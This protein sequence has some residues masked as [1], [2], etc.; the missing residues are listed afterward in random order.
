MS[1]RI[2]AV[3]LAYGFGLLPILL[4]SGLTR[5]AQAAGPWYVAPGGSDAADCLSPATAC[6]TINA[7]IGKAS[8]G[9]TVYVAT[10]TY[11]A[12]SGREVVLINKSLTLS[13]G[14]DA[15]FAAQTGMAT[16][17]GEQVRRGITLESNPTVVI[18]RFTLQNG[19]GVIGGA[20][21]SD[22]Y[23]G[24]IYMPGGALTVTDSIIR[25]NV[26]HTLTF[27]AGGGLYVG[28]GSVVLAGTRI[29]ANI[30]SKGGG[31]YIVTGTVRL[32]RS[33][34]S[35]NLSGGI[36]LAGGTLLINHSALDGNRGYTGGGLYV[37][38]GSATLNNS[39]VSGN[40][41]SGGGG[42]Y[43][44]RDDPTGS[45]SVTLNSSTIAGN[46]AQQGG[47]I[48]FNVYGD[49]Q[50]QNTILADNI[51]AYGPNCL[52]GDHI[53]SL[54][55]NL[56]G[57]TADCSLT[58][59][60]GDLSGVSPN[61]GPQIAWPG[62]RPLS[63]G[64]PAI[65]AGPAGGCQGSEG[66]LLTDQ[67]QAPRVGVCDIGAYEFT[68]PGA[69]A[70]LLAAGGSGQLAPPLVSFSGVLQ[71]VVVDNLGTPVSNTLVTFAAPQAGASANFLDT[72]NPTMTVA[73][74]LG[75]QAASGVLSA[76]AIQ[77]SY[78]VTATASGVLTPLTF[79]LTNAGWYVSPAGDDAKDCLSPANACATINGALNKPTFLDGGT[80]LVATGIYTNS[81]DSAVV[82]ISHQAVL[83]GG[84]T[85]DFSSQ[86]GWSTIDGEGLRRG[87]W[88]A[89]NGR[90]T[91]DRFV[92]QNGS[93]P[94]L[95]FFGGGGIYADLG[96]AG[97]LGIKNSQII[98]NT[99]A[100][101]GGGI[102]QTGVLTLS[103]STVSNNISGQFG[104]GIVH[105]S[106]ATV[107]SSTISGNRSGTH[108]GGLANLGNFVQINNSTI[109]GNEA[110]GAGGGLY[111]TGPT[112]LN[113]V[114]VSDNTAATSGGGVQQANFSRVLLRN[115]L[116]A[117]NASA[118]GPDCSGDLTSAGYNLV[119]TTSQCAWVLATGDLLN[120]NAGLVPLLGSPG[121]HA[122]LPTS[123][124]IDAGN[125]GGCVG[126]L[127]PLLTDQRGQARVGVC[128]IGAFEYT[129]PGP[130]AQI[131]VISGSQQRAKPLAAYAQSLQARVLDSAGSPL[132]GT[133]V[134]FA[135]PAAGQSVVFAGGSYSHTALTDATGLATTG[136]FTAN[137]QLGSLAVTASVSGVITPGIYSLANVAWYV[138][139]AGSDSHDCASPAASCATINRALGQAVAGDTIYVATG[140]YTAP[141]GPD[142]VWITRTISLLGGWDAAFA[143]QTGRST[144]NGGGV[145]TG[146]TIDDGRGTNSPLVA[147][148]D[149]F[150][151]TNTF[152]N[153]IYGV[154]TLYLSRSLVRN[155]TGTGLT[156][157]RGT[158]GID[159]TSVTHHNIE[160][161]LADGTTLTL[162]NSTVSHNLSYGL[163]VSAAGRAYLYNAT[164]ANNGTL[165]VFTELNSQVWLRN[166]LVG[167][168]A[169]SG[170]VNS[171]GYNLV[172]NALGCS[173][174]ASVGDQ[175]NLAAGLWPELEAPAE[176]VPLLLGSR[177]INAGSPGGCLDAAGQ[178]LLADQR[179]VAR[180]GPCDV[181]AYEFD[182]TQT[183]L[184]FVLLP[185]V[186]GPCGRGL[187][188]E[189][190]LNGAPVSGVALELRF[191]NGS[192]WSTA[193]ATTTDST[194]HYDFA[195]MA[196]LLPGQRYYVRY[197]NQANT[198]G[199]L[200][201]WQ[202]RV[203]TSYTAGTTLD[204]GSFDIGDVVLTAPGE[205]ALVALPQTFTWTRRPATPTDSYEF[206]IYD[207][208]DSDPYG[209]TPLLGYV[210][211]VTVT[212][213]PDGFEPGVSYV[214]EVWIY[215]P[216]G[217]VGISRESRPVSF[218]NVAAASGAAAGLDGGLT[219]GHRQI[220]PADPV[221]P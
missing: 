189:V 135:A 96:L 155:S 181:G 146:I 84:W 200:Y 80:V 72:G 55:H 60:A 215:S 115:S 28:A 184:S 158:V 214:W 50:L 22:R 127:G 59:A 123:P 216:D 179:G 112:T 89:S 204:L 110:L 61:L 203:R 197:L 176:V 36:E 136:V 163:Q 160:G 4:L 175:T 174:S 129:P 172:S 93:W 39:T 186:S 196:S 156:Y 21:G 111:A 42:I 190:R 48:S 25:A 91:I 107:Y 83:S 192:T 195:G 44:Q 108:G 117:A 211:G 157:L 141:S 5:V 105:L 206:D 185:F 88:I 98:S 97:Q 104:G 205:N 182:R 20:F 180:V 183:G 78:A 212:G 86:S 143:A 125:P 1:S 46:H 3:L 153:G 69:A 10:G 85:N 64:S 23:G 29:E 168:C 74:S 19:F 14:W 47:G 119:G 58:L 126:S 151:V 11:T 170:T 191:Y 188:G 30:A 145:R 49:A 201:V 142:V 90:V 199:R 82:S 56:F 187:C 33:A 15:A 121:Y 106:D 92:V 103:R 167:V 134:V 202:T 43:A 133:Q 41:A 114:T 166:S 95:G 118:S 101:S 173:F 178:P 221:E 6:A 159:T 57:D 154:G 132:S 87:I 37:H 16:V 76:N 150:D 219:A 137:A 63:A 138:S 149:R 73:S 40:A 177:A 220:R 208:V 122:L 32:D 34:V 9:D 51:S 68:L 70:E 8:A 18:E 210:S 124:A 218:S 161:I 152:P 193:A 99:A 100:G 26:A 109:S 7:A 62:Y 12:G 144:V 13:G 164:L 213:L 147:R 45:P 131:E 207:P 52:Y 65:N 81:V 148:L 102:F 38:N 79:L 94:A 24:G 162:T 77:G 139:P 113:S 217:G 194:G 128:D 116:L 171:S 198:P 31:L 17:E 75:G 66:P 2:R 54:G 130:P 67:R 35:G 140:T 165:D 71:A 27:S 53:V 209:Y 169:G 120:M